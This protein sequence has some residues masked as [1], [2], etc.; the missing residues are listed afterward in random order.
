MSKEYWMPDT[1]GAAVPWW[2]IQPYPVYPPA[3]PV[4]PV[5]Q[6]TISTWTDA[7]VP[8]LAARVAKLERQVRRL[9]RERIARRRGAKR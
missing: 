2:Q 8:E 6:V 1:T 3:L 4:Q 5:P 7:R 9:R